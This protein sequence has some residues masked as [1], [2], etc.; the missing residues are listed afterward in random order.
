MQTLNVTDACVGGWGEDV[1]VCD[2]RRLAACA[3]TC[4]QKSPSFVNA[5]LGRKLIKSTGNVFDLT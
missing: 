1:C 3:N 5:L 4:L 2:W